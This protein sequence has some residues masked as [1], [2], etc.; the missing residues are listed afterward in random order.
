MKFAFSSNAF[1]RYNLLDTIRIIASVGY[2]GIEIMADVPHAYPPHLSA[3]DIRDI[4]K[5]LDD[6]CLEISNIN[7]FMHH[8]DGDT[9]HPSW[10]EKDPVLRAKRVDYTLACI[11]L[12]ERLGAPAI[13][14]EPGG[15]LD[16][17][18]REEGLRFFKEGLDSVEGRARERGI[19]IL[20]EPEPGLLIENSTQFKEFFRELDPEVFGINFD[21]GHFFC[22]SEDPAELMRDMKGFIHHFHLE[23]IAAS[24]EHHHLMLGKG[25][26]DIPGILETANKIGYEGFVTVELYTYESRAAEAAQEAFQYLEKWRKSTKT[27]V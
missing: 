24:R 18:P 9:Y 2:Q 27:P 1:L 10:I 12:A 22:V 4:R 13:S 16:G 23:D 19:R 6:N 14:T 17:L 8:A 20:I 7:A 25:A 21:I 26:I 15:P 5:A 11:D 3:G